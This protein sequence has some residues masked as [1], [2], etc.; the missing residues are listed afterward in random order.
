M[1]LGKQVIS[2]GAESVGLFSEL[3][4]I[5][6]GQRSKMREVMQASCEIQGAATL[7]DGQAQQKALYDEADIRGTQA[8][9]SFV[10]AGATFGSEIIGLAAE[11]AANKANDVSKV[12]ANL[13]K[14]EALETKLN[15][16]TTQKAMVR[17]DTPGQD[18][19]ITGNTH[20]NKQTAGNK[21]PEDLS[22]AVQAKHKLTPEELENFPLSLKEENGDMRD[23]ERFTD[24]EKAALNHRISNPNSKKSIALR[25][26]VKNAVKRYQ[27]QVDSNS[28]KATRVG[29]FSK[30]IVRAANL[31]AKGFLDALEIKQIQQDEADVKLKESQAR[32]L[33]DTNGSLMRQ[34]GDVS[35]NLT[36]HI[37]NINQARKEM[38][39]SNRA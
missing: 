27:L 2:A 15:G 16:T 7:S 29:S 19:K 14:A 31:T 25:K 17:L 28:A 38:F 13:S 37:Q 4:T 36:N 34:A 30:D 22:E 10:E 3:A 6:A 33:S 26:Q 32:Y 39:E 21:E 9:Q 8:T 12:Q 11:G 24:D 20:P 5:A 18:P 23:F 1:N 35:S